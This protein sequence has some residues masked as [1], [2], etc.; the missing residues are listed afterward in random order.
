MSLTIFIYFQVQDSND[1]APVF[2]RSWYSMDVRE[3]AL[4]GVSVGTVMASDSD[5]GVNAR[6]S[7]SLLPEW[8]ADVFSLNPVTGL[9]TLAGKLDYEEVCVNYIYIPSIYVC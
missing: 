5:S 7:Y 8:G 1:N 3:D 6:V 4:R 9:L 2:S